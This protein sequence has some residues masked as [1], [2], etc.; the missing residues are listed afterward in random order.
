LAHLIQTHHDQAQTNAYFGWWTFVTK[1]NLALAAGLSLPL[2]QWLGYIP[3]SQEHIA[4]LRMAYCFWPCVLKL[5]AA[6]V[7]QQQRRLL[8]AHSR[9]IDR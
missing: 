7:L 8:L 2:L 9:F 1:L 3:S 4:P 6:G 5:L